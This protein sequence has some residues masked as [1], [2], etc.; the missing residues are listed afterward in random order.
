MKRKFFNLSK[1]I[2]ITM[3]L[4]C[5][6]LIQDT[7]SQQPQSIPPPGEDGRYA[8]QVCRY[9]ID[10]QEQYGVICYSPDPSGPCNMLDGLCY[11]EH[12]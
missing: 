7:Q 8:I 4:L 11:P 12:M 1:G 2:L 3:C 5:L 9:V 6:F 10:G